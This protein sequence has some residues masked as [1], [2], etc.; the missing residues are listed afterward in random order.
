MTNLYKQL[1]TQLLG[2]TLTFLQ[3]K[4]KKARSY[5][6]NFH[7][8]HEQ[9]KNCTYGKRNSFIAFART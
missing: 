4:H 3:N 6:V 5:T 1:D 7:Y 9:V 2:L 8:V